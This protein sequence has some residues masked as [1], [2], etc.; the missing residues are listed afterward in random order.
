LT[1]NGD[2]HRLVNCQQT[3]RERKKY[4]VEKRWEGK[5]DKAPRGDRKGAKK[6]GGGRKHL[7]GFVCVTRSG[8][9]RGGGGGSNHSINSRILKGNKK[10][11]TEKVKTL[12]HQ[13]RD[14]GHQRRKTCVRP[15]A[16]R[17]IHPLKNGLADAKGD[18]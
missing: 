10:Y 4:S 6:Q 12:S 14:N 18:S 8:G 3:L 5:E 15:S 16:L 2:T 1:A 7:S 9:W 13:T 11:N 17:T